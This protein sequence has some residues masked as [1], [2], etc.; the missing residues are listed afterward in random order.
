MYENA[1]L[2][3]NNRAFAPHPEQGGWT[4][5]MLRAREA[6]PWFD[7]EGFLLHHDDGGDLGCREQPREGERGHRDT[8]VAGPP[9]GRS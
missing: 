4:I 1:W 2:E 9:N 8:V 5:D 6:E 3:V 7:P